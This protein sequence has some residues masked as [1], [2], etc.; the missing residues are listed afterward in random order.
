VAVLEDPATGRRPHD[1][2]VASLSDDELDLELTVAAHDP[3]RRRG[4]YES[5]IHEWL[6]RQRGY[7]ARARQPQ[8]AHR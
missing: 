1:A 4:R 5:L 3:V 2:D 6:T 8:H 7:R